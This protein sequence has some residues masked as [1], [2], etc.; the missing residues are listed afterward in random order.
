M[1]TAI[2]KDFNIKDP[3]IQRELNNIEKMI[4]YSHLIVRTGRKTGSVD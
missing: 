4:N 1:E 3:D 2:R